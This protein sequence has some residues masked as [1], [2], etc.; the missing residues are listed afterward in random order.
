[1][2]ASMAVIGNPPYVRQE[3]IKEIKPALKRAYPQTYSGTADL[4]VYFYEKGLELLRPGGRLSYVVTNKWMR[5]GYAEGL[6]ALFAEK[7]WIEFVADF[8]HAKKFFPDADVFPSVI[9]V[10]KP[11]AGDGPDETQVCAVS[12][13]DVPEKDLDEFVANNTYILSRAHFTRSNWALEQPGAAALLLKISTA[14]RL[15]DSYGI[16]PLY[17]IK[18]GFNEAFVIDSSTKDGLIQED[19]SAA[20]IIKP[21]LRGQDI[22]RWWSPKANLWMIFARR[23]IDIDRYPS[24]KKHLQK[25]R[26]ELE[27]KPADWK[28]TRSGEKWKGR[29]AGNYAWYEIQDPV[30]YYADFKQPKILVKRIAFHP[31]F[32]INESTVHVNDSAL[33]LPSTDRWLL[34]V[35]NAPASW[36]YMFKTFPH[37]KDE[38][39][40]ID[41]P[42]LRSMPIP[43]MDEGFDPSRVDNLS[44]LIEELHASRS[45]ILDWLRH[46][47]GLEKPNRVLLTPDALDADA[48]VGEVRGVLPKKRKLTAA[49]IGELR[50][51]HAEIVEPARQARADVFVLE[52]QLSD[53]V[54][55]AFGLTPEEVALLWR[56]APPR[57]PFTPA[58]LAIDADAS[59]DENGED[60]DE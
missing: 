20:E 11:L 15:E 34:A 6:R 18:T 50:R 9:V 57:M 40:S 33:I 10:R 17:G 56:T 32:C 39:V 21:F 27:P 14:P 4:Y 51:E 46:E 53:L 22:G 44:S 31:R 7:A 48:F 43:P 2:A 1:M 24:V 13:D 55:K 8:G 59:D 30:E 37:K 28:P 12:R 29:K 5:A 60:E 25:F 52:N 49:E 19:Q 23:G 42:F 54:N 3:L 41:T 26:E 35:L 16:K 45:S 58:G 38:A 36:Y 47:F